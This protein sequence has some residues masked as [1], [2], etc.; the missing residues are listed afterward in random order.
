M[1]CDNVRGN[2]D[3][4]KQAESG[5]VEKNPKNINA[6]IE[7]HINYD[8]IQHIRNIWLGPI[9]LSLEIVTQTD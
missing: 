2:R 8:L 9:F 5:T 7:T 1:I 4:F 3:P 6:L